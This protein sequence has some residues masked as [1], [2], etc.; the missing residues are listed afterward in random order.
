MASK[1]Q[2][3]SDFEKI[4]GF[5][6][7]VTKI[8]SAASCAQLLSPMLT[9]K[10]VFRISFPLLLAKSALDAWI[11]MSETAFISNFGALWCPNC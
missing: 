8:L 2:G 9:K 3:K 4:L 6:C 11:K 10:R 7:V 5:C 1:L